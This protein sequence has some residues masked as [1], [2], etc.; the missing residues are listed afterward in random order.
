VGVGAV[1]GGG[2]GEGGDGVGGA[3]GAAVSVGSGGSVGSAV[4]DGDD[5]GDGDASGDG[6]AVV[7]EVGT[8]AAVGT[9]EAGGG[10]EAGRTDA[11]AVVG[12][13]LAVDEVAVVGEAVPSAG[14]AVAAPIDA[15]A[16]GE[17]FDDGTEVELAAPLGEAMLGLDVGVRT[18]PALLVAR[19]APGL[20]EAVV[21]VR[22]VDSGRSGARLGRS[23]SAVS[24]PPFAPTVSCPPMLSAITATIADAPPAA[25]IDRDGRSLNSR[26]SR[27]GTS[28]QRVLRSETPIATRAITTLTARSSFAIRI[29]TRISNGQCHR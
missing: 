12:A 29:G 4:P 8:T 10:I 19:T 13:E 24:V 5:R 26:F 16:L 28:I 17:G 1:V 22:K 15:G 9:V 21:T 20:A 25:R 11:V 14:E 3:V 7:D 6:A 18:A 23:R 27:I 2:S